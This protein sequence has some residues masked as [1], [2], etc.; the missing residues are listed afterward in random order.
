MLFRS[1]SAEMLYNVL[2]ELYASYPRCV[3]DSLMN[4]LGTHDTERIL[5]VLG[6]SYRPDMPNDYLAV[7]RM[8]AE[9]KDRA[10]ARLK[11][12]SI[13]QYTVYGIPS[14]FYGDEAGIE[15]Y[16]DPFCRRTYPW[17]RENRELIEHYR[18][19]GELRI[20]EPAF[21]RGDFRVI[22]H[23]V[24]TL[25]YERAKGSSRV[26]VL[27]NGG[28]SDYSIELGGRWIDMITYESFENTVVANPF[29][30]RIMKK[31]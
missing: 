31:I 29:S 10:I 6:D 9:E 18:R 26:V 19:L 24:D 13:I 11:M 27:A 5:T 12:A 8:S 17:G 7:V 4:I 20:I 3:S 28:S 21:D 22:E 30:A 16:H 23:G 25:A 1:G 15:G 2:V 14:V